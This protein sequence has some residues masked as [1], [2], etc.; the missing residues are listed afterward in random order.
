VNVRHIGLLS[1]EEISEQLRQRDQVLCI[2]NNRRHARA[3]YESIA[4][5]S[6]VCHLTTLM[7]AGHRRAVLEQVREDL[8]DGKPCRLVSTSLVEAGVDIDFPTVLRAEAGLDSIAQAAG[9]CNRE[10]RRALR[11]SE[12]LVF[13]TENADWAPPTE[14]VQFA[15]VFRSIERRHAEDLLALDAV[16]DYFREL[17]WQ[18]GDTELDAK[19]LLELLKGCSPDNLPL[20]T[21]ARRFQ[22]IETSMCPI[23]VPYVP[24]TDQLIPEVEKAMSGLE[25]APG[26]ARLLQPYLVQVPQ[27]AFI[28]LQKSGA[29]QPVARERYG[30]QFMRLVNPDLYNEKFGL[31]WGDPVFMKAESLVV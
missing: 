28:S 10:G 3:L 22:F 5:Q 13:A 4:D 31:H 7:Y 27:S 18:K 20:E 9:R 2:V 14:L 12:T 29:I 15:Q 1:D 30:E 6:G 16:H 23:I 8:K 19:G 26:L 25:Y 11:V 17:Y 24:G 21:L